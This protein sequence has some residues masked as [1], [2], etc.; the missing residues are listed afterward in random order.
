M[1]QHD[2]A[3]DGRDAEGGKKVLRL[4]LAKEIAT[5]INAIGDFC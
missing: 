2:V 4:A 5:K 1:D 3:K